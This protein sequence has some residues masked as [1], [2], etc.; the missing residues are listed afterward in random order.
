[1]RRV[2]LTFKGNPYSPNTDFSA[3]WGVNPLKAAR[4]CEMLDRIAVVSENTPLAE[5]EAAK[6]AAIDEILF[7]DVTDL[8]RK[9]VDED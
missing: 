4:C 3:W 8:F 9:Y 2:G 7:E 6:E 5:Q 1:M